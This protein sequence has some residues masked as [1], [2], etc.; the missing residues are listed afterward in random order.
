MTIPPPAAAGFGEGRCAATA[1]QQAAA[2]P[3]RARWCR[4]PAPSVGTGR[5]G[6]WNADTPSK[7]KCCTCWG[8]GKTEPHPPKL[9]EAGHRWDIRSVPQ[10]YAAFW[11]LRAF[12]G[13]QAPFKQ[14]E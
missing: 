11:E 1:P 3:I 4:R 12:H 13:A 7:L 14:H 6:K 2:P 9:L 8:A 5:S 10:G